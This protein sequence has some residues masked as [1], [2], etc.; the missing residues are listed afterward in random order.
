MLLSFANGVSASW[1][2]HQ[3]KS[4]WRGQNMVLW[5]PKETQKH[6]SHSDRQP[7]FISLGT[8]DL[9]R[10]VDDQCISRGNPLFVLFV[11][12]YDCLIIY[13]S[14]IICHIITFLYIYE[15]FFIMCIPFSS[16]VLRS[17]AALMFLPK[18]AYPMSSF[19]VDQ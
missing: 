19:K 14:V 11:C 17:P 3:S 2:L 9:N 1:M 6:D 13:W 15:D 10:I 12:F 7:L 8:G 18:W 4:I 5:M 16:F